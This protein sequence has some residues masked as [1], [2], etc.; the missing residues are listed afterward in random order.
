MTQD[1]APNRT[2]LVVG[3]TG[4]IGSALV[5]TLR[6]HAGWSVR[7]L[8]RH[9]GGSRDIVCD[10]LDPAA[11]HDALR[12][13]AHVTHVFHAAYRPSPSPAVEAT[14]NRAMLE[15]VLNGLRHAGAHLRRVV[16]YQ[17]AKVYGGHL[18]RP[19][20]TPFYED[21]PRH[22]GPNLY[23]AMEDLL[24]ARSTAE[25][26]TFTALRPDTVIGDH[27][28]SPFN[29]G[30]VLGAFAALTRESGLTFRFPGS[31]KTYARTFGQLTDAR[32]LGEASV[33]AATSPGAAGQAFNVVS[34]PFRW[35]R[36]W[37]RLAHRLDLTVGPIQP[38]QLGTFAAELN[39]IWESI[40]DA[41][42]LSIRDVST[43]TNWSFGDFVLGIDLDMI[44]DTGKLRRAGFI[45]PPPDPVESILWAFDGLAKSG[46]LPALH[47]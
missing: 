18:G 19:V 43:L 38:L 6:E 46:H 32:W 39:S 20:P 2:A 30:A 10:V 7:G 8:S 13:L 28:G 9:T 21:A 31:A 40:A 37:Q 27:I 45:L 44:S 41:H 4:L 26:W 16:L 5:A 25:G 22:L 42:K 12:D 17:G 24:I 3:S 47:V 36:V 1:D 35:E 11:T 15:N 29:L 14:E 23:Y 34:E 33:W